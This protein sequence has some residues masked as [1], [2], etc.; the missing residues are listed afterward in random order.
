MKQFL[1]VAMAVCVSACSGGGSSSPTAATPPPPPAPTATSLSISGLDSLRTGFYSTYTATL[2]M[3]NGTT[4]PATNVTWSTDNRSIAEAEQNGDVYANSNGTTTIRA[5]SGNVTG[6]KGLRV[7]AN[8]SGD[9][10]GSYRVNKC[11]DSGNFAG[12]WCRSLGGVG[13]ILPVS[14]SLSQG[15]TTRDQITGQLA[16]G[17]FVGPVT[18]NVTGD[19]RLIL[20]GSFT[21]TSGTSTVRF[22]IGGWEARLSNSTGLSGGWAH[23]LQLVGLTGNVYQENT[24]VSMT[25]SNVTSVPTAQRDIESATPLSV[26]PAQWN[27]LADLARLMRQ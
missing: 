26:A 23:T 27:T 7:V 6:T 5:T 19:G 12:V 3:S 9:W 4:Q 8:F 17:S 15:G 14:M 18:G 1:F 25:Q 24:F 2:T 13:T 11:D 16:L 10:R 22:V 21:T 20:G